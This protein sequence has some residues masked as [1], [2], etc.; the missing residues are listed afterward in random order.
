MKKIFLLSLLSTFL[1]TLDVNAQKM[2]QE[3][4]VDYVKLLPSNKVNKVVAKIKPIKVSVL[5]GTSAAFYRITVFQ[6][7]RVN[8]Y[9]RFYESLRLVSPDTLLKA[10]YDFDKHL[11]VANG[12]FNVNVQFFN[13]TYSAE[14]FLSGKEVILSVS[15]A[16]LLRGY[17]IGKRFQVE[18][19]NF[20]IA[21]G[22]LFLS[23]FMLAVVSQISR[24][25][26]IPRP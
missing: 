12:N 4:I 16:P 23:D 26:D 3:V 9:T 11:L 13:N 17:F 18:K 5:R 10:G 22:M 6:P 2:L 8:T 25:S 21:V 19:I 7:D 14:K 15:I 24:R 1:L 20:L